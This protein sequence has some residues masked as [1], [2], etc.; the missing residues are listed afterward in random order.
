MSIHAE[1][2]LFASFQLA[3]LPFF[4]EHD[5]RPRVTTLIKINSSNTYQSDLQF[6]LIS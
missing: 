2:E 6:V 4:E 3:M 5:P 1:S